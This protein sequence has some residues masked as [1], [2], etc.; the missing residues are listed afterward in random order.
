MTGQERTILLKRLLK[1]KKKA[2][3]NKK[4]ALEFLKEMGILTEKGNLKAPY[5]AVCTQEEVA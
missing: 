3:K 2:L 1:S 4:N 5:K